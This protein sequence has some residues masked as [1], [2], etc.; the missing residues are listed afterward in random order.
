MHHE[1]EQTE[2]ARVLSVF[3]GYLV[4]PRHWVA[5]VLSAFMV[6]HLEYNAGEHDLASHL[7]WKSRCG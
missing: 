7:G 3:D 1:L 5:I 4:E 6:L 2:Y